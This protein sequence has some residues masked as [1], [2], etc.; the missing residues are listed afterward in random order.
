MVY[1]F[2][3]VEQGVCKSI[4]EIETWNG[5]RQ[6]EY[7]VPQGLVE[8]RIKTRQLKAVSN[9][10]GTIYPLSP[11]FLAFVGPLHTKGQNTIPLPKIIFGTNCISIVQVINSVQNPVPGTFK[12]AVI[13]FVEYKNE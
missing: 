13:T 7:I 6:I 3:I 10:V 1:V 11:L 4:A 5:R 9:S 12:H 2:C 8:I